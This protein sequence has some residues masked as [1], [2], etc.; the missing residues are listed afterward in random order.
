MLVREVTEVTELRLKLL[1]TV[2]PVSRAMFRA[3]DVPDYPRKLGL[4]LSCAG[5]EYALNLRSRSIYQVTMSSCN[6]SS[7]C[8]HSLDVVSA[9][10]V[11]C[12][13]LEQSVVPHCHGIC[14]RIAHLASGRKYVCQM[15]SSVAAI[16]A[17][18][19]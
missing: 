2:N 5:S 6:C 10:P 13:V 3:V 1:D 16:V 9:S 7:Y 12:R 17:D 4:K 19:G 15:L 8:A 18:A 11:V 14:L